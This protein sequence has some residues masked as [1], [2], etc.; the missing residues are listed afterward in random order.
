MD[1]V[2]EISSTTG[3]MKGINIDAAD[4]ALVAMFSKSTMLQKELIY[5]PPHTQTV[6]RHLLTGME[7]GI[8]DVYVNNS[9]YTANIGTGENN[10]LYFETGTGTSFH[11]AKSGELQLLFSSDFE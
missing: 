7:P 1:P 9:L 5:N 10:T 8:Y 3:N 11:V 2:A 6:T 4:A